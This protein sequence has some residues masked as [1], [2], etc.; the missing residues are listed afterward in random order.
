[1][2]PDD[3]VIGSPEWRFVKRLS[4]DILA[5]QHPD[6]WRRCYPRIYD[7]AVKGQ[8]GSVKNVSGDMLGAALKIEEGALGENEKAEIVWASKLAAYRVP[9]YWLTR[10]IAEALKQTTPSQVID[11][12][13]INLPF[14]AAA[15][16]VP[17]GTLKHDGAEG[18][19]VFVS[20]VRTFID[21]DIRSLAR[22]GPQF[23]TQKMN[24]IVT[25]FCHTTAEHLLHWTIPHY[26]PLDLAHLDEM[27][28]K[29]DGEWNAH[30]SQWPFDNH[31]LDENDNRFMARVC[32]F[33]FN[34]LLLMLARPDLIENGWLRKRV[35]K[36][37]EPPREFWSP[38]IIGKNYIFRQPSIPQGGTHASP[39]GHW[40]RGFLRNQAY[41]AKRAEHK[42]IWIEPFWRGGDEA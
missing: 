24:S 38:S 9:T 18:E 42:Q 22:R 12:A 7:E 3:I 6:L 32:H 34:T 28:R 30:T 35:Q 26:M 19:A 4:F 40:V 27:I 37:Q 8:Y 33:T 31:T 41:G 2:I 1:M 10:D 36:R 13:T 20:Y 11:L 39:R 25:L 29:F 5:E 14:E 21:E 17:A 16:M 23:W 15:F